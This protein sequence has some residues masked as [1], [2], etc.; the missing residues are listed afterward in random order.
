[1]GAMFQPVISSLI[2][3]LNV[4]VNSLVVMV[5][6]RC[7]SFLCITEIYVLH[8][9]IATLNDKHMIE[10]GQLFGNMF[11]FLPSEQKIF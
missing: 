9:A 2:F 5:L 11:R 10:S 1:M 3:L 6:L 4:L 8:V 7:S